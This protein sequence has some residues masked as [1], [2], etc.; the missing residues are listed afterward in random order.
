M[1]CI[2]NLSLILLFSIILLINQC[3]YDRAGEDAGPEYTASIMEYTR[4]SQQGNVLANSLLD[5]LTAGEHSKTMATL[6]ENARQKYE[7]QEIEQTLPTTTTDGDDS[8]KYENVQIDFDSLRSLNSIGVDVSFLTELEDNMKTM[9]MAK[10]LQQQLEQNSTLLEQL[11]KVQLDRLSQTLP[12][13]LSH[14]EHANS[15]EIEL[16][17]QI[18]SNLTEMAKQLPPGAIAAPIALRKA[19]GMSNGK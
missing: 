10:K 17:V 6:T 3:V 15:D 16:A 19:M 14:I 18:T 9:E 13:H 5:F 8:M 1:V 7:Q 11:N 2:D 4:D 12:A